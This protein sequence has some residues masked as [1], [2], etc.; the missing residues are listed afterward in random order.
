MTQSA[1]PARCRGRANRVLACAALALA[2][3][4]SG[5]ARAEPPS[6][7]IAAGVR[8][9]LAACR[10]DRGR[11]WG[12]TLCGPVILVD[13]DTRQALVTEAP[14]GTAFQPVGGLW[15]GTLP[16][17]LGSANTSV[18]WSGRRWTM[19]QLPLP[20]D[21]F[22]RLSLL[23]H[24]SF[25]R[26]QPG[27][28]LDSRDALNPHLDE[29][30]GR[31]WLRLE[32]RALA[33]ALR[34][35]GPARAAATRDAVL[36]RR[37]RY[38]LYPTAQETEDA[39]E[40]HEGLAEYTGA[41][42]GR[43]AL[44]VPATR[45]ADDLAAFEARPTFVRSLGYGTGPALG[46]LLDDAA[47]AWRQRVAK[48]GFAAQL[49][50]AIR[51][52]PPADLAAAAAAAARRYGAT[53]LARAEDARAADRVRRLAELRARLVDGPVVRFHQPSL[54]TS[55]DPNRI[56]PL[57]AEGAVYP[58]G[59]FV[60]AWGALDVTDGGALIAPDMM[61]LRVPAPAST[62]GSGQTVRGPG[63]TL[64]LAAGWRLVARGRR[65]DLELMQD[66]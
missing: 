13:P 47:P 30:D 31:Y 20:S 61:Q 11:L 25:H 64:E 51:F 40:R 12:T 3:A 5:A 26:I 60:A 6:R 23:L 41:H 42:L 53:E 39:L 35:A 27:L 56:I 48:D 63:W 58:T 32:L 57:G 7:D 43:A 49:A 4:L 52:S 15:R 36:F 19:V 8:D 10:A 59:H 66:P 28:R 65:G 16:S 22:A 46:L 1:M 62:P 50:R 45:I 18:T 33:S 44:R 38:A 14:P 29:R 21:R 24:E 17:E 37:M 34:Q 9:Y 54:S 55:F 2:L